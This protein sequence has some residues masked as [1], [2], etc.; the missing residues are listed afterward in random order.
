MAARNYI[1][2]GATSP[3]VVQQAASRPDKPDAPNVV[4]TYN[5]VS[6]SWTEP[7]DGGVSIDDY[8]VYQDAD[9]N[10]NDD[11]VYLATTTNTFYNINS[12]VSQG[13][14]YKFRI[15]ARNSINTSPFSETGSA[16]AASAPA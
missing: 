6:V 1:G 5:T 15:V 2:I 16:L 10:A 7:N 8:D 14:T 4:A 13:T 3:V 11:F 12:G 9:N